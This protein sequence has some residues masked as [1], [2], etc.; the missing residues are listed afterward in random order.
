MRKTLYVLLLSAS[1][2][3]AQIVPS[4]EIRFTAKSNWT[5]LANGYR[6]GIDSAT[7]LLV[8]IKPAGTSCFAG[9]SATIVY[10]DQANTYTAGMKQTM[11]A[12]ATT[13]GF[14]LAG[15]TAD[16]SGLADGDYWFRSDLGL[17]KARG[18]GL[19]KTFAYLD[20]SITGNAATA[21][22]SQN[23]PSLCSAGNYA[24]GV[25]TSFN[26]SGCTSAAG[27]GTLTTITVGDLPPIFTS[28]VA[29]PTTT[30]AVTYTLSS[31]AAHT[32]L[33]NK[34][35][36][37]A[38]PA[39]ALIGTSDWSPNAY[40]VATGSVNVLAVALTPAATALTA[41]LEVD[42]LPNLANTTT[43]PTL[44]VNSLGAKTIM[45]LGT[46]ALVVNDLTTT[47]VAKVIY[48]GT[49]WQLQNPQTAPPSV[50]LETA[51]GGAGITTYNPGTASTAA[52]SDHTHRNFKS[53]SWFFAGLPVA[54]VQVATLA[55]PE[56]ITNAVIT[57]MRVVANTGG[58]ATST[59]NIQRCTSACAGNAKVFANIYATG[60]VLPVVSS[61]V[62]TSAS[63]VGLGTC[64]SLTSTIN[65]G[66]QFKVN[67]VT[68]GTALS[69]VTVVMTY[70]DEN[71]N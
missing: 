70:K 55:A 31:F 20:S 33:G 28:G 9:T 46:S 68:V 36:S 51:G 43:T 35:S 41:G 37:S 58:S 62:G 7:G 38:V 57:D 29:N 34:T 27:G 21:T 61:T 23:T 19:T 24:R 5:A 8:C 44:N 48:D 3:Y 15:V 63:C 54:G 40:A 39:A 12:S 4:S 13:A 69:D 50:S 56:G 25:D 59:I 1:S 53:L 49:Q 2:L 6:F 30:P 71:S 67:L 66:D 45:K 60:L 65:A 14:A 42:F 26:A 18:G 16:P 47:A 52:R 32:F 17:F 11:G 64:G 22:G 10:T